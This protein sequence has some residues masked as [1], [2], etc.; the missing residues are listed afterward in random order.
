MD[1]RQELQQIIKWEGKVKGR[2]SAEELQSLAVATLA[3]IEV[4]EKIIGDVHEAIGEDRGSDDENL[5]ETVRRIIADLKSEAAGNIEL[6]P[7]PHS[8]L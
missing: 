2:C 1:I 4:L 6:G 5:A 3:R 8:V 7:L